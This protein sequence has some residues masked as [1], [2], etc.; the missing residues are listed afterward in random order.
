MTNNKLIALDFETY[1]D[2]EYSLAK[3]MSYHEYVNHPKFNAYLVSIVGDGIRYAGHPQDFDWSQL[4][5]ATVCIH[6]ARFDL[7]VLARLE[8][9]DIVPPISQS[10]TIIDTA[11]MAACLFNVRSLADALECDGIIVDK[12]A[13]DQAKGS[14]PGGLLFDDGMKEYC[15][16]DSEY[17]LMFAKK[18]LHEWSDIERKI[19]ELNRAGYERGV[20]VNVEQLQSDTTRLNEYL[21]ELQQTAA[22]TPRKFKEQCAAAGLRVPVSVSKSTPDG[23]KWLLE[24]ENYDFV[25]AFTNFN[26]ARAM[27]G[28]LKNLAKAVDSENLYHPE[29]KYFGA[30]TGRFSGASESSVKFNIQNMPR[31]PKFGVNLRSMFIARPGH[32]LV[33]CDYAQI[34]PRVLHWLVDDFAMLD[35]IKSVGD[36]YEAYARKAGLYSKEG[37]LKADPEG[38]KLR[39]YCKAVVIAL[40]YGMGSK[41]FRTEAKK[42]FGIEMSQE[43]ADEAVLQYRSINDK[44]PML[45]REYD[46]LLISS[47]KQQAAS[48][49]IEMPSGRSLIYRKPK[50]MINEHSGK[51][52]NYVSYDPLCRRAPT[53]IW[54]GT[55][56]EN[57]VQSVSR[58]I[59]TAA[60]VECDKLGYQCLFTVH[61]EMVFEVEDSKLEAAQADIT[62]CMTSVPWTEGC[63]VEIEIQIGKVYEK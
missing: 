27:L 21:F 20:L 54:G 31:S 36:I 6:N 50:Q 42:Q 63:P 34:E 38:K 7:A 17:C 56:V 11:D 62:H 55:L 41:K 33:V 37:K 28:R 39:Q 2:D 30:H 32:S 18:H 40:G 13:R 23:A 46:N 51:L 1:Y 3:G 19:S 52:E 53:S 47:A 43:E 60:W 5:C 8:Q 12:S 45:W 57:V 49:K 24:H 9:L 25:K 16:K 4:L 48:F 14:L 59:L 26:A 35:F 15:L 58:D 22:E 29:V 44:I 61:D 10:L